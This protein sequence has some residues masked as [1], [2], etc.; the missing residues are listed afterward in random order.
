[1]AKGGGSQTVTQQTV[2]PDFLKPYI[3]QQLGAQ[4][5]QLGIQTNA[6][7]GLSDRLQ[8]AT[9]QDLVA[10]INNLQMRGGQ[11]SIDALR[12]GAASMDAFSQGAGNWVNKMA[13]LFEG[14]LNN[15][16][17]GQFIPGSTTNTLQGISQNGFQLDP[18]AMQALQQTASG[19]NLYGTP[20]FNEAVNASIRAANPSVLNTFGS[21]GA[22][23]IKSGLA[24]VAR[25]QVASDAFSRLYSQERQNQLAAAGQLG[26]FG[27]AGQGN[28]ISAATNLGSL[29]LNQQGLRN[30][31]I[32]TLGS[33]LDAE[34]SRQLQ[35]GLFGAQLANQTGQTQLALGDRLQQQNQAEISAPITALQALAGSANAPG[36]NL[37][38]LLGSSQS[39]PLSRNTGA[40]ILGGGLAGAQAASL[41]G[42]TGPL[43]WGLAA[44]GALLGAL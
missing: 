32:G 9:G 20:A 12:N 19:G 11:T 5:Q 17:N 27:L 36:L 42:A 29:N 14:G 43:G 7:Q 35:A 23:A 2:V 22:G 21:A 24:D 37:A 4:N 41:L 40:G 6:L 31:A 44:G 8:G 16:I 15:A 1:M 33:A 38:S 30:Q 18:T 28:Q 3:T 13:P 39:Q 26:Q 10:P 34:R 25:Q